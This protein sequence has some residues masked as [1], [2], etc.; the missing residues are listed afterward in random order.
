MT[1]TTTHKV[2]GMICMQ[3]ED[4]IVRALLHTPGVINAETSYWK[5]TVTVVYNDELISEEDIIRRMDEIGYPVGESKLSAHVLDAACLLLVLALVIGIPR[6][7]AHVSVPEIQSGVTFGGL[8]L[9]G[10][11]TGIHCVGMCGGI[12]LAQTN[13]ALSLDSNRRGKTILSSAVYNAG[14]IIGCTLV[15]GVCGL[16]G[17]GIS[18]TNDFRSMLLT[19]CGG[20]VLIIGLQMWGL[21]PFLRR[22]SFHAEP[23]AFCPIKSESTPVLKPF[24]IGLLNSLMPCGALAAMW[25]Y[26]VSTGSFVSGALSMLIFALGTVPFMMLFSSIGGMMPE[27]LKRYFPKLSAVFIVAFGLI[28]MEKGLRLV[29]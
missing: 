25:A 29:L 9:I 15:G 27:K 14:R 22:L 1:K 26:A 10:L 16:L 23:V 7:M 21:L 18:Y 20:L 8:F 28:M 24:V 2:S 11:F 19:I 6:L 3:C 17:R 4:I 13:C 5:S 12:A